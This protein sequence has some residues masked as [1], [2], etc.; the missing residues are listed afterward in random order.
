MLFLG[1]KPAMKPASLH[2]L[3]AREFHPKFRVGLG[4]PAHFAGKDVACPGDRDGIGLTHG[5]NDDY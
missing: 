4:H 5:S 1:G 2:L 3:L